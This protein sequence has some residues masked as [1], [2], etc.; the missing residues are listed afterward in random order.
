MQLT[1]IDPRLLWQ[2]YVRRVGAMLALAGVIV[3][4]YNALANHYQI[5]DTALKRARAHFRDILLTWHW[6]SGYGGVYIERKPGVEA[7]GFLDFPDVVGSDGRVYTMRDP[8]TMSREIAGLA[9]DK[10]DHHF[11]ITSLRL[12]NP[13]NA[14]D[15]WERKALESFDGGQREA[16]EQVADGGQTL[17]RYMAPMQTEKTCHAC[18]SEKL[19][20]LGGVQGGVS[21]SF[22]ITDEV[23][24][25]RRHQ[26]L[27]GLIIVLTMCGVFFA[28]HWFTRRLD[29]R[30]SEIN[31]GF[32]ELLAEKNA[33]L[34]NAVVGIAF[35]R[36]G[37]IVSCNRRCEEIFGVAEGA[38]AG[39]ANRVLFVSDAAFAELDRRAGVELAR[40]A[41]FNEEIQLC[42]G[43]GNVF[44]GAVTGQAI[45]PVRPDRGAIWI[46]ADI[47]KRRQAM[48]EA[49]KLRRAVEQSPVSIIITDRDGRIEYVNPR[50][51]AI[52]GYSRDEAIGRDPRLLNSRMMPRHVF[53]EL[54]A[55]L[56]AGREWRGELLNRRKNGELFWEEISISPMLDESGEISHF[57]A[58][59]EDISARKAYEQAQEEHQNRLEDLV[60][61]R[62]AD[63]S[64]ALAA[65]Q[66][67]DR[68]KTE[69]LA[70]ISHE[71]RTPL[72][73]V[74]GLAGLALHVESDPAMRDYLEKIGHAGHTLLAIINDLLDLSKIA[75]G[76]LEL[77]HIPFSVPQLLSRVE[78]LIAHRLTERGL[79]FKREIDSRLPEYL[80]GDP[81]RLEQI[82]LNLLTN[83]IK[84]TQRGRIVVRVLI[85]A[86]EDGRASVDLEVED[87]GIGLT[88]AEIERLFEPFSQADTSITRTHGGTGL[89][90]NICRRLAELMAGKV[91]V[92]STPGIGSCFRV[93]V[94]LGIADAASI[95]RLHAAD[96]GGGAPL[97][98]RGARVLVVDD[99]PVN[100]QIVSGLLRQ[101]GVE[102]TEAGNG[103]EALAAIAAPPA[104]GFDL[105][106]M[107]IQMPVMDGLSAA[108]RIR[109]MP[110]GG[111]LPIVAMTAHTMTH[112]R[113]ASVAAGMNDHLGKPFAPATFHAL[114]AKWLP[115][116]RRLPPE[117]QSVE[118]EASP[119]TS[120]ESSLPAVDGID[121]AAGLSRFAGN[122]DSY[123]RWL[124]RFDH[125]V[126]DHL[127]GLAGEL[128]QGNT[129]AAARILHALKGRVGMLGLTALWER[130]AAFESA[131]N[132]GR[133]AEDGQAAFRRELEQ[134]R[135]SI[136]ML[137][138]AG[139]SETA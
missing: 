49:N 103:E 39:A 30:L 131:L 118:G 96:A 51:S 12:K 137:T 121:T 98:Y 102:S 24:A 130:T 44:W 111:E 9:R 46:Y 8:D 47:S 58:V 125:E 21:V 100:R 23:V 123:L 1:E 7:N 19:Y 133:D 112:E 136:A 75:A 138:A 128:A 32:K 34:E 66:S 134:T 57:I 93:S 82:L 43:D 10:G 74:I 33:I 27:A 11:H 64:R 14:P 113:Q 107:D 35:V 92:A 108:R 2:S 122:R 13:E 127:A 88:E 129:V 17:F 61:Q 89:G 114:L 3:F 105:V 132:D 26:A 65:A 73:A 115:V 94:V 90:L 71:M 22:D 76:R 87:T 110:G 139:E 84:F 80:V 5:Q 104:G 38:L 36:D 18:H 70:N 31:R 124:R 67:A 81:L 29:L 68:A 116:E 78:S 6:N 28:T 109:E 69:F 53:T 41:T 25:N 72:N 126:D 4:A 101:V 48:A 117:A 120:P 135:Q 37:V 59:K 20:K 86:E 85:A 55:T 91:G 54:W 42:R 97:H 79:G 83:A 95:A 63:L 119:P 15:A 99:Q 60:S 16:F 50:F 52:T 45:D 56:L 106:F 77:E 62:T 40:G